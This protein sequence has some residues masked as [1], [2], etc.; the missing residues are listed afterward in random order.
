MYFWN[1]IIRSHYIL[2]TFYPQTERLLS[3]ADV[4][5]QIRRSQSSA[6]V[7]LQGD[8][9]VPLPYER[10][11]NEE[12]AKMIFNRLPS[13]LQLEL[14]D[15]KLRHSYSEGSLLI[16]GWVETIVWHRVGLPGVGIRGV[17][18]HSDLH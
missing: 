2:F 12:R 17:A 15:G 13:A 9:P 10:E 11:R 18:K 4:N 1:P 14:N 7:V 6:L 3:E 5:K 16:P 8:V